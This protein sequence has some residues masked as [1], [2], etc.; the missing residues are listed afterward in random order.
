MSNILGMIKKFGS[1]TLDSSEKNKNTFMKILQNIGSIADVQA[2]WHIATHPKLALTIF[3]PTDLAI[4]IGCVIY[5]VT[6]F[7][8]FPDWFPGGF[9]DDAGISTY[10]IS[11]YSSLIQQYRQ[12]AM[13]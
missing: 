1:G 4:I 7:D 11:K 9:L 3:N 6:P 5:V 2:L 10:V 8:A 12:Q 13:E